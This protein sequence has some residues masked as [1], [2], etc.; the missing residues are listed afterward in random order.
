MKYNFQW[1]KEKLENKIK[2]ELLPQMLKM[3]EMNPLDR[4]KDGTNLII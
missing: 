1:Y 2:N 4:G 3:Q